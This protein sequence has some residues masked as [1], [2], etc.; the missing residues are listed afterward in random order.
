[1]KWVTN[2]LDINSDGKKYLCFEP[3]LDHNI[4]AIHC[5]PVMKM[6]IPITKEVYIVIIDG[7]KIVAISELFT[8]IVA[9]TKMWKQVGFI[10]SCNLYSCDAWFWYQYYLQYV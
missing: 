10:I 1:M 5:N 8:T 4:W 7:I 3:T 2:A 9:K 6:S